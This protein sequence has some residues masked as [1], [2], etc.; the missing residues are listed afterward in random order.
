MYPFFTTNKYICITYTRH[1]RFNFTSR[2]DK[3]WKKCCIFCNKNHTINLVK[4]LYT[5]YQQYRENVFVHERIFLSQQLI[6]ST[7][8]I[9]L[10]ESV[11]EKKEKM[12]I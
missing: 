9:L 7:Q 6:D 8:S 5:V 10:Y 2:I 11:R 12:K 1:L 4:I 3:R